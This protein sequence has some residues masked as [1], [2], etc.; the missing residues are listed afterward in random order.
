M[1]R[2]VDDSLGCVSYTTFG[3]FSN[4]RFSEF[5]PNVSS[6]SCF[7]LKFVLQLAFILLILSF[8]YFDDN[9]T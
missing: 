5:S 9:F 8:E 4:R 2:C 3:F 7:S 1:G 6:S